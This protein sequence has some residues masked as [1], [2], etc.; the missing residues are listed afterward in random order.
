MPKSS[1]EGMGM[2]TSRAGPPPC[3]RPAPELASLRP[4]RPERWEA[5]LR[6]LPASL[7]ARPPR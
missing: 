7:G 4:E 2:T 3:P 6:S 5:S 1:R